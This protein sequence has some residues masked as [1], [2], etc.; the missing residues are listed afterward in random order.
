M[1]YTEQE[2]SRHLPFIMK[3]V[4]QE[5]VSIF[6]EENMLLEVQLHLPRD[7]I[8]TDTF[9]HDS[10]NEELVS[11]IRELEM[12]NDTLKETIKI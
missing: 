12:K 1:T 3:P 2:K 9:D 7:K 8:I 11:K 10:G 4:T 5:R 6:V